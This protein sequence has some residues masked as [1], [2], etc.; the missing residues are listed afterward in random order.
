MAASQLVLNIIYN[1]KLTAIVERTFSEMPRRERISI[2]N[3][4]LRVTW[5]V[6]SFDGFKSHRE[7]IRNRRNIFRRTDCGEIESLNK[8]SLFYSMTRLV[9]SLH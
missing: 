9:F 6:A 5:I 1:E 3:E 2:C 8:R 4:A 7:N